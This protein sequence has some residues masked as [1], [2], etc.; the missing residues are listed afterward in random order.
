MVKRKAF[1][2]LYGYLFGAGLMNMSRL[3]L[4][5]TLQLEKTFKT[6]PPLNSNR[7]HCAH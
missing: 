3:P 6:T 7:H 1:Q 2:R 4:A 5:P